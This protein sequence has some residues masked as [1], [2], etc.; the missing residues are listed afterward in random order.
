MDKEI[1]AI[2]GI[3]IGIA[4]YAPYLWSVYKGR[5]KPHAFSWIIWGTL[6]AIAFFAQWVEGA[7]PGAWITAFTALLSFIIVGVALFKGEKEI[8]RSDWI[9]FTA[10]IAAIPLWYF[11]SDPLPAVILVTGI[12]AL[13]FYPTFRKSWKRPFEEPAVSYLLSGAKFAVSLPA[14]QVF[15]IIT[16]IYPLSHVITNAIFVTMILWRRKVLSTSLSPA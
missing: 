4:S 14:L 3:A 5:S 6:T 15:S 16:V 2:A 11:T 12:D 7:G 1:F 9:T 13:G 10:A 8:T